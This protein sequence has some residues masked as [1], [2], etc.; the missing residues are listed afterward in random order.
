MSDRNGGPPPARTSGVVRF[1]VFELDLRSR[2]LRKQG[3]KLKL[4]PRAFQLLQTLLEHPGQLV[5]RDELRTR[6]W[7]ADVF[8]DFERAEYH[9][10]SA[11]RGSWRLCREPA[12]CRDG[13]ARRLPVHCASCRRAGRNRHV[14]FE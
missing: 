2:E 11:A 3:I 4:Q 7:P 10:E 6:L 1:G 8:V 13:R 14:S 12:V 5:T 9:G